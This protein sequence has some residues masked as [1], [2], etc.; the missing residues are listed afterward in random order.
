MQISDSGNRTVDLAPNQRLAVGQA[1][2]ASTPM[3]LPGNV[4]PPEEPAKIAEE[5]TETKAEQ[6]I[7]TK[8]KETAE[9]A[10]KEEAKEEAKKE[11]AEVVEAAAAEEP[12]FVEPPAEPVSGVITTQESQ[13]NQ[14]AINPAVESPVVSESLPQ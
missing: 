13:E 1:A 12:A 4:K 14:A 8:A 11:A 10:K 3:A 5:K 6:L 2:G 7:E 9:A